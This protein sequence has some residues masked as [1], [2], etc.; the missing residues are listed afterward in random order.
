MNTMEC[1]RERFA[2][3]LW[4]D[5]N[6]SAYSKAEEYYNSLVE[7]ETE[8]TLCWNDIDYTILEWA[9]CPANL[10]QERI[11]CI[12]KFYGRQ[13]L[14]DDKEYVNRLN[15]A[16]RFWITL[17]FTNPNWW[18]NEIGYP[19]SYGSIALMMFP[20][21][22]EDVFG[23]IVGIMQNGSMATKHDRIC[24]WTG[25]NLIWGAINTIRHALLIGDEELFSV[26]VRRAEQEIAVG[27]KEGIQQDACFFQHGSRVYSGGYGL[28]YVNDLATI[29]YLLQGT[30]HQFARE[31]LDI[32]LFFVLDGIRFMMHKGY[33]DYSCIGRNISRPGNIKSNIAG[34]LKLFINNTD[35]KRQNELSEFYASLNGGDEPDR[36]KLFSSAAYICHHFDGIYVGSKFQNNTTLGAEKCNG[37]GVLC[38]NMTYG[39]NTCIMRTGME[40]YDINCVWDFSRIPGTTARYENDS[41]LLAHTDMW[42]KTLSSEHA[43]SR[44]QGEKAIVFELQEHDG[45]SV[46]ASDFAFPHGMVRLGTDIKSTRSEELFTTVDQCN[47]VGGAIHKN[48]EIIHNGIRY[49]ALDNTIFKAD[50]KMQHGSWRRNSR[51]LSDAEKQKQVFTVT[52]THTAGDN[53]KYAYMISAESEKAPN[54]QV[55]QNDSKVQAILLPDGKVMA[56]FHKDCDLKIRGRVI[57]GKKGI[58]FE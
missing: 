18:H 17:N 45:I 49:T 14:Y 9:H 35:I 4:S 50:V 12:L 1:I 22:N 20:F 8:G 13:R 48:G 55:I 5:E 32:L 27:L 56:V 15:C 42:D 19:M 37:E 40:Y 57:S 43:G 47:Y 33:F 36:I 38:Y 11:L 46:L 3:L 41:E 31:K 44:Q 52:V 25:A 39:T 10:H 58:F 24:A 23:G 54:I 2:S 53:S 29:S 6:K 16:I 26:A 28:S 34:I 7:G 30:K 51:V 21:L